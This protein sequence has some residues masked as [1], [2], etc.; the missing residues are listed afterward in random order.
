MNIFKDADNVCL[1]F[2]NDGAFQI[3]FF[4]IPEIKSC[5]KSVNAEFQ[6]IKKAINDSNDV[7]IF[8][9]SPVSNISMQTDFSSGQFFI[10]IETSGVINVK[11]RLDIEKYYQ[12]IIEFLDLIISNI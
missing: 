3:Y 10:R 4:N 1:E 11:I 2:V 12:K 8:F 7:E 5:G 6:Y 9:H